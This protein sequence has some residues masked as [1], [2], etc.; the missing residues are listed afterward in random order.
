MAQIGGEK[1]RKKGE[2]EKCLQKECKK[3]APGVGT[4][5]VFFPPFL[6]STHFLPRALP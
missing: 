2:K 4:A 3:S 1:E 5:A 6:P